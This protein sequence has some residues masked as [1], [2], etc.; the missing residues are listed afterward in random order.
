MLIENLNENSLIEL[1]LVYDSV[2]I[3]SG[4][5][6]VKINSKM[7]QYAKFKRNRYHL[8]LEE[9]KKKG[10]AARKLEN[11]KKRIKDQF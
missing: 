9:R 1:H 2:K 3:A 8:A 4:I 11:K 7:L 5:E 10:E 6:S